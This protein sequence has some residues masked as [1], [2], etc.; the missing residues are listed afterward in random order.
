[1]GAVEGDELGVKSSSGKVLMRHKPGADSVLPPPA[2]K[3]SGKK[4]PRSNGAEDAAEED[5]SAAAEASA[6]GGS[7]GGAR[8]KKAGAAAAA[9]S[10]AATSG[11]KRSAHASVAAAAVAAM[12]AGPGTELRE[13]ALQ[14]AEI[15]GAQAKGEAGAAE[16]ATSR[17]NRKPAACHI[18]GSCA[19]VSKTLLRCLQWL[20]T[21]RRAKRR[22]TAAPWSG[23]RRA[24]GTRGACDV[25]GTAVD[26]AAPAVA[27]MAGHAPACGVQACP[28]VLCVKP[29]VRPAPL[30]CRR[31]KK[32]YGVTY[33]DGDMDWEKLEPGTWRLVAP[34]PG[35]R[36]QHHQHHQQQVPNEQPAEQAERGGKEARQGE[37]QQETATQP[38]EARASPVLLPR[39]VQL[40]QRQQRQPRGPGQV[41]AQDEQE[42][43]PSPAQRQRR[44]PAGDASASMQLQR[45][46]QE[47]LAWQQDEQQ[48]PE[49]QQRKK[50]GDALKKLNRGKAQAPGAGGRAQRHP[51]E[52]A[53]AGAQ[54]QAEAAKQEQQQPAG[55]AGEAAA[56]PTARRQPARHAQQA[57]VQQEQPRGQQQEQQ[58]KKL[59]LEQRRLL[60]D[61]GGFGGRRKSG[62][63]STVGAGSANLAAGHPQAPSVA[64]AVEA[65]AEPAAAPAPGGRAD[66]AAE[67][68]A[69]AKAVAAAAVAAVLATEA[70]CAQ[71]AAEPAPATAADGAGPAAAA[72]AARRAGAQPRPRGRK[73]AVPPAPEAAEAPPVAGPARPPG[74]KKSRSGSRKRASAPAAAPEP[75]PAAAQE[76][77]A[78]AEAQGAAQA[79]AGTAWPPHC[80]WLD[81]PPQ[82]AQQ[83]TKPVS[84]VEKARLQVGGREPGRGVWTICG[85][86]N[87]LSM[88]NMWPRLFRGGSPANR[89]CRPSPSQACPPCSLPRYLSLPPAPPA[90]GGPLPQGLP[91]LPGPL[92]GLPLHQPGLREGVLHQVRGREGLGLMDR[93]QGGTGLR[94]CRSIS[95][96]C[97]CSRHGLPRPSRSAG[98]LS[99]TATC[100]AT[101][102]ATSCT[103]WLRISAGVPAP[104][105]CA[106]ASR[107]FG[108]RLGG[109]WARA[110]VW[111]SCSPATWCCRADR[112][113][114]PR[115]TLR[116]AR[117]RRRTLE[118]LGGAPAPTYRCAVPAV[119]PPMLA[120][121]LLSDACGNGYTQLY[122]MNYTQCLSMSPPPSFLTAPTAQLP[123]RA[124]PPTSHPCSPSQQIMFAYHLARRLLPAVEYIVAL[125]DG[126]V[127]QGAS[128]G[129]ASSSQERKRCLGLCR[130]PACPAPGLQF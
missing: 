1:M 118:D 91:R 117:C 38:E 95:R 60:N 108:R 33:E 105:A 29:R 69:A 63:A 98:A 103:A 50:L 45:A 124:T 57:A 113:S 85:H 37:A 41:A 126:Q 32:C 46:Q 104:A 3:L 74:Y 18:A 13:W 16:L 61:A 68:D 19:D 84:D 125:H 9:G 27:S 70:A 58:L 21:Q 8:C 15:E 116:R 87:E 93:L 12:K 49:Q 123:F 5:G 66:E 128:P 2:A 20:G 127:R 78:A 130:L 44:Q 14:G 80:Y 39:S 47:L 122:L 89:P 53:A 52:A 77:A 90:G 79:A 30:F 100:C 24:G 26:S 110:C 101:G 75:A 114:R 88:D 129:R 7:E 56:P 36:Q 54:L 67:A 6:A 11:R 25:L 73:A 22:C 121:C 99:C 72:G 71:A 106:S 96:R 17:D 86:A 107:E 4:R 40:Q 65:K 92:R 112:G 111:P 64:A 76:P 62:A 82:F 109:G 102:P 115:H 31:D 55:A 43:A 42:A 23:S 97:T 59:P 34:P 35:Q 94:V 51:G 48:Q 119:G 120:A 81:R 10:K 28:A 83:L